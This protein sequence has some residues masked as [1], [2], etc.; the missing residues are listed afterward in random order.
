MR[1]DV[2]DAVGVLLIVVPVSGP[3]VKQTSCFSRPM[4][5]LS[6]YPPELLRLGRWEA[7]LELRLRPVT[8]R[9]ILEEYEGSLV[10][11][12]A[13]LGKPLP[14]PIKAEAVGV[15]LHPPPR[16]QRGGGWRGAYGISASRGRWEPS[17]T[18]FAWPY[19]IP[20]S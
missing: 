7:L 8:W 17:S 20:T 5:R 1:L 2:T 13:G 18:P 19:G 12:K 15:G 4:L 16:S 14:E 10:I 9:I 11:Y 6:S 3:A